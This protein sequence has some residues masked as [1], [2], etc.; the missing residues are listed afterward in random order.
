MTETGGA[1]TTTVKYSYDANGNQTSSMKEVS[2]PAGGQPS[3]GLANASDYAAYYEYDEWDNMTRSASGE[4]VVEYSYDGAGLR[5]GKRVDGG[6]MTVSLYEYDRVILEVNAATGEQTAVNVHGNELVSRNGQHYMHN[7]RGDVTAIL[8]ASSTVVAFYRYDAFGVHQAASGGGDNPYRYAGYTYDGETGLYY[9]RPRYYDPETARFLSEDTYL[10]NAG[11][12]LS[13]NLYAYCRYNPLRYTDPTGH[14]VSEWDRQNLT[15]SDQAL[16]QIYTNI[17]IDANAAGNQSAMDAAHKAAEGIRNAARTANDKGTGDGN[18]TYNVNSGSKVQTASITGHS[19]VNNSGT[20]VTMNVS[21]GTTTVVNNSGK[22][23]T[24]NNSGTVAQVNNSGTIG[25]INNSGTVGAV[26]NSGS[27]GS[28]NNSGTIGTVSNSGSIGAIS[29]SGTIGTISN[30]GWVGPINT[31]GIIVK[32]SSS[33]TGGTVN[34]NG[35]IEL[36]SDIEKGAID[37]L[38]N[39]DAVGNKDTNVVDAV[40]PDQRGYLG[41]QIDGLRNAYASIFYV[42]PITS[43]YPPNYW[44]NLVQL[45][46]YNNYKNQGI[47]MEREVYKVGTNNVLDDIWESLFGGNNATKWDSI[48]RVDLIDTTTNITVV[49]QGMNGNGTTWQWPGG[50]CAS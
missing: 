19:A 22:I 10:G 2:A 29:N 47:I 11:D 26:N 21:A 18:T 23:G 1:T 44:H 37:A 25:T 5:Y 4:S 36:A 24:V 34:N 16:I 43:Y 17:W 50:V 32:A 9:L 20:I 46:I 39:A 40:V 49:K 13:L 7:G 12:P 48:G 42:P 33:G 8:D 14:I 27:I 30:S 45:H 41:D 28:V 38:N 15:S 3:G 31:G 35:I 6:D